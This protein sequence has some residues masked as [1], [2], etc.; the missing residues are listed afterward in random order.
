MVVD[1]P[2]PTTVT[3]TVF[4]ALPAIGTA[5]AIGSTE[6]ASG[7]RAA[8]DTAALPVMLTRPVITAP[9]PEPPLGPV[10]DMELPQ[11]MVEAASAAKQIHCKA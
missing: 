9:L 3:V 10:A 7:V 8:I 4:D 1:I 5:T 11:A 2:V 6:S